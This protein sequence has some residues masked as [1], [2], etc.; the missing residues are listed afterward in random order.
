MPLLV[1]F[2]VFRTEN[3]YFCPQRY[4]LGLCVKKYPYKTLEQVLHGYFRQIEWRRSLL[5]KILSYGDES[6][7]RNF[8]PIKFENVIFAMTARKCAKKCAQ[9]QRV[10]FAY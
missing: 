6:D 10:C 5:M 9:V 7:D 8:I 2:R 1:S 3:R 4:R